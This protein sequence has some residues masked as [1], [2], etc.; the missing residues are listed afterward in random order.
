MQNITD[1]NA[2]ES[3]YRITLHEKDNEAGF[4]QL[5]FYYDNTDLPHI[6]YWLHPE[7]RDI[8]VMSRELPKYLGFCNDLEYEAFVALVK[9]DNI[10]SKKLLMKNKFTKIA[11]REDG[12]EVY[13]FSPKLNKLEKETLALGVG[14]V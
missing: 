4:I 7:Y 6:E 12:I 14:S 11:T 3:R 1:Y 13:I 8:G 2:A 5:V 9:E 10:A